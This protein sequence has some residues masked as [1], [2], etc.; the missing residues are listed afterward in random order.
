[1][2]WT[3]WT[4]CNKRREVTE[5]TT[6]YLLAFVLC[7]KTNSTQKTV[8][9]W[10]FARLKLCYSLKLNHERKHRIHALNHWVVF[11]PIHAN[12]NNNHF[13]SSWLNNSVFLFRSRIR[14]SFHYSHHFPHSI[15]FGTIYAQLLLFMWHIFLKLFQSRSTSPRKKAIIWQNKYQNHILRAH[16]F[17]AKGMMC[18]VLP[19]HD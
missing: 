9:K 1:M 4:W 5:K 15:E 18:I 6:N 3:C 19:K 10:N 2:N 17:K 7:R 8:T 13:S 12:L 11:S 16:H 14:L